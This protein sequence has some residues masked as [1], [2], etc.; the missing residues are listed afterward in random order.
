[1]ATGPLEKTGQ[2]GNPWGF[3]RSNRFK[4]AMDAGLDVPL[5]ADK[6]EVDVLYWVGC[7]GAYDPR[8]Q[9]VSKAMVTIFQ[10]AGVDYAVLGEEENCTGDSAR[11]MGEEYLYETLAQQN[12]A[13]LAKYRFNRIITACPHCF[14]TLGFDY[15]QLGATWEVTHHSVY[16]QELLDQGRLKLNGNRT[17]R[18]TY[19]DPCYLGRHHRIYQPPREVLRRVSG[20][21]DGLVEMSQAGAQSFCCG[22]GGG[23][24]WYDITEGKRINLERFDQALETGADTLA[25]ACSFCMIMLDDAVKVRGKE[26]SIQIRD[27][28]ELAADGLT[29]TTE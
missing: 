17:V 2:Q 15:R 1:D 9:E 13:T 4:W 3:P 24:M 28:A 12:M 5:M 18:A 26:E 16:I 11:R 20:K 8:N 6:Q 7:A 10:A 14:Q 25:T 23:N 22:A 27:I 21:Q 29:A 19:H